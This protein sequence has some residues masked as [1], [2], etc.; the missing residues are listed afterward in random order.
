MPQQLFEKDASEFPKARSA[1]GLDL[2][3]LGAQMKARQE[4]LEGALA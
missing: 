2:D 1:A 3:A 4:E